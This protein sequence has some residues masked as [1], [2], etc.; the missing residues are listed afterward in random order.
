MHSKRTSMPKEWPVERKGSK[1][2]MIADHSKKSGIPLLFVIR[3]LLKL[4][5]TRKEVKYI[6]H[7]GHVKVNNKVR[8]S[9]G[10]PVS[11]FDIIEFEKIGKSYRL[12]IENNKFKLKEAGKDTSHKTVKISGKKVIGKNKIQVN[13]EDGHNFI[14][15]ESCSVGDSAVINTKEKKLEKILKLKEGAKVYVMSGKHAGEEGKLKEIIPSEKGKRFIVT[16]KNKTANLP[17]KT[18]MVVE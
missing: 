6:L 14:S 11:V 1:Y 17:L 3:N 8:K 5:R 4:A 16:F 18:M 10:F 7:E 13:L 12:E 9:E 15:K 2:I